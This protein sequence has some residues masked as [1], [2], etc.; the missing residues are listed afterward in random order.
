MVVNKSGARVK[1]ERRT[2]MLI[3]SLKAR[4]ISHREC[5]RE[6]D[7]AFERFHIPST[8]RGG[9]LF[10]VGPTVGCREWSAASQTVARLVET[11][12]ELF[13]VRALV[14]N[15]AVMEEMAT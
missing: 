13:D 12:D 9:I 2:K 15:S 11:Q 1:Y 10:V 8:G 6:L 4:Q 3:R 14:N 7:A 5:L